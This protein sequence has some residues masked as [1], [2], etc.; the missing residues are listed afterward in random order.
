M[1]GIAG[2]LA[3]SGSDL[4]LARSV[5]AMTG[6]LSHRGPNGSGL[7]FE[8]GI[9]LG[10]RRLSILELTAAGHQ[11]MQSHC[12]RYVLAFNGEIY[13]H[14]E[15]RD[16]LAAEGAA[17]AWR[18][19]SDT[20]T[21]LAAI[22]RWGLTQTLSQAAGM[23]AIALWD[24]RLRRLSLARDRMGE[25]P[26]Y[27][28]WAR[29]SLVFAS[30]LKA[31]R[32]V[33]GASLSISRQALAQYTSL[34]YV[35]APLSIYEGIFKLEPGCILEADA[36]SPNLG[37]ADALRPGH[38]YG[39]LDIRRYWWLSETLE[40][41]RANLVT[42]EAE[43]LAELSRVMAAAVKRQMIA[44][45][46]LGAFLSGGIDSSL[47]AA[48]MQAQSNAPIRT[49]TAG[50]A[51]PAYN[52]APFAAAVAHHLGTNHTEV[53]V[54]EADAQGVI[55]QLAQLYDEPFG[56][57]S[58]IP[59]HLICKIARTHVTVALSG[60]GGD[61]LFGGYNRYVWGEK[62][63]RRLSRVPAGLRGPLGSM[64]NAVPAGL[65]DSLGKAAGVNHV[66]TKV[67]RV[68]SQM[69]N[70]RDMHQFYADMVMPW[71]APPVPGSASHPSP[72]F[73]TDPLAPALADD[74][75]SWMMG[76]DARSYLP[77]DI[78]CKVDRAAMGVSLETR[79]PAL[80]PAVVA[81][82]ARLPA[83][84]RVRKGRGK[85][86]LRQVLYQYVPP[87]LIERPKTGF[88]IPIGAWL[89]GPLKKWADDLLAPE[90]LAREGW[91]DPAPILAR[92]TD[93]LSG[94]GDQSHAIWPILMFQAWLDEWG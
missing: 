59:T 19:H 10:H 87:H 57:S 15:L 13:N 1:C 79:V 39:T 2:G 52:E 17:P 26:L 72:V 74:K 92:W 86:A 80:D 40:E 60:D 70:L 18:G 8:P 53:T 23:F 35:P 49:F 55:P 42:D 3:L 77:D 93:H 69:R 29:Q 48:L 20:E 7:W 47:I 78:L 45:V 24:K 54:T 65:Y 32:Q 25:K 50:F 64:L 4:D 22:A 51:N 37:P 90:R 82:A 88:S 61:E 66:A 27:W 68:T 28:G 75:L 12:G 33:K 43:G 5:E 16:R 76:Q 84:M 85:W 94:A 81:F 14:L 73:L 44:D 9:A 67:R 71:P 89:R 83:A 30:E 56:D 58:Q 46:P 11:P 21:L 41:G 63:W 38:A 91:L 6:A 31:I 34:A 36:N 62:V